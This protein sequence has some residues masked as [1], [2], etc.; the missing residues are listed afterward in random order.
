MGKLNFQCNYSAQLLGWLKRSY[1]VQ[2]ALKKYLTPEFT[3]LIED[4]KIFF[5]RDLG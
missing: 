4:L 5:W 2:I 3:P 1:F